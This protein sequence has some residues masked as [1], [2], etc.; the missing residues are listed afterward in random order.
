MGIV[1]VP[2]GINETAE[3]ENSEVLG[4]STLGNLKMAGDG[5][6]AEGFV[7]PEKGDD[8]EPAFNA[9]NTHKLSQLLERMILSFH[10]PPFQYIS[11]Y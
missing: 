10:W 1:S 7:I 5:I 3:M 2:V 11:I 4:N 8:S 6:N 9:Q